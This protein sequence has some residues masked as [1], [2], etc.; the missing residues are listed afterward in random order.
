[1]GAKRKQVKPLWAM[2]RGKDVEGCKYSV[3]PVYR[4]VLAFVFVCLFVLTKFS[5]RVPKWTICMTDPEWR[6]ITKGCHCRGLG[7]EM[8]QLWNTMG[9]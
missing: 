5:L 6:D 8:R 3:A 4:T 1:M 2:E 9:L 7:E